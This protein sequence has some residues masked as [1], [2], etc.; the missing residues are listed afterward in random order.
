MA[1]LSFPL[2]EICKQQHSM[3]LVHSVAV[4]Y[5]LLLLV[6]FL[7]WHGKAKKGTLFKCLVVLALKH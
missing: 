7:R 6:M 5:R 2:L 4:A 3:K 1:E